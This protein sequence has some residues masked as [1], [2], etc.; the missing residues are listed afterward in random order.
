MSA[1]KRYYSIRNSIYIRQLYYTD[2][3]FWRYATRRFGAAM[4]VELFMDHEKNWSGK[5]E[6]CLA[7]ARGLRDG[8]RLRAKLPPVQV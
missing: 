7:A 3:P 8:L 2:Y 6:G 4:F 5:W 1:I